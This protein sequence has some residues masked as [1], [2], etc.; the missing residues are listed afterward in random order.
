MPEE[1]LLGMVLN[2]LDKLDS[3]LNIFQQQNTLLFELLE[4]VIEPPT[5]TR[6]HA[7]RKVQKR[8]S[9]EHQ[10]QLKGLRELLFTGELE[11]L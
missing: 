2:R 5:V 9:K 7:E 3:Q 4:A 11:E 6:F 1:K 10:K 8:F